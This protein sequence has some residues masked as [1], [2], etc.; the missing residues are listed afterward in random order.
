ME[1]QLLE[2]ETSTMITTLQPNEVFVFG[3]NSTGFHGAG[4][5]GL[6]CRGNH[7]NTW[8]QDAWFLKA[9]DTTPG[10][11]DRVGKWA[12]YGVARGFQEGT[13][14]KSYAIQTIV[15]PGQRQSTSLPEIYLQLVELWS[16][17]RQHP[18]WTFLVTPLGEGYAGYTAA[19]M[20]PVW[21]C[22]QQR[23]G[24]RPNV[25]FVGRNQRAHT[26]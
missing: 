20:K 14:G 18:E 21:D 17:V 15:R 4:A 26:A 9:M 16:F 24:T 6:A 8:R 11:A 10:S 7:R 23:H 2:K 25:R 13:E 12:I 5:S 22:L 3:S 19:E 1:P